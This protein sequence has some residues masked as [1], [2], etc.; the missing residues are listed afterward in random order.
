MLVFLK[1]DKHLCDNLTVNLNYYAVKMGGKGVDHMQNINLA[2]PDDIVYEIKSLPK[3]ETAITDK[4]HLSL[5]IGM[6]VSREISLAKAAQ[7]ANKNIFEFINILKP[8]DIPAVV[9]TDEM[10]DDDLHFAKEGR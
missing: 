3:Q 8:L 9:Y 1:T 10:L 2:I 5:A 7:L 6:F 4:L